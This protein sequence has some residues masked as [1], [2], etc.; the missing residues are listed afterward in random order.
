MVAAK[1]VVDNANKLEDPLQ[2]FPVFR[3]FS[4]NNVE[5]ELSVSKVAN[6]HADVIDWIFNLTKKNMFEKYV[7]WYY[8]H[9]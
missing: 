4:K 3:K 7:W 9:I 1:I 5:V 6:L 2:P 8:A